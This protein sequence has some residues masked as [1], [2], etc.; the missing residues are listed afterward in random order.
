L[1]VRDCRESHR[2]G[3]WLL[4]YVH[5]PCSAASAEKQYQAS[6]EKKG[7]RKMGDAIK[8]CVIA[9]EPR[10]YFITRFLLLLTVV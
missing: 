1:R 7:L 6:N 2:Y 3:N 4:L 10:G 8:I 9:R 5:S